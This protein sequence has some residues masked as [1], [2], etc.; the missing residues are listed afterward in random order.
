[1]VMVHRSSGAVYLATRA[2]KGR[3]AALLLHLHLQRA[4]AVEPCLELLPRRGSRFFEL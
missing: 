2:E 1:M 3:V 4:A